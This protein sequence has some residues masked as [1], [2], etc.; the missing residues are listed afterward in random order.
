MNKKI[1]W[2]NGG[3]LCD[4]MRQG[5]ATFQAPKPRKEPKPERPIVACEACLD[6]HRKGKHT[7]DPATRKANIAAAHKP[8]TP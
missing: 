1:T 2:A 3:G 7:S 8:R 6:W 4:L 5:L